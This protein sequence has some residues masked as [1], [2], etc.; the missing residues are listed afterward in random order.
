MQ[1]YTT[2]SREEE[3]QKHTPLYCF[4]LFVL[5]LWEYVMCVFLP[6]VCRRVVRSFSRSA[7]AYFSVQSSTPGNNVDQS[8]PLRATPT[9]CANESKTNRSY[10]RDS[11]VNSRSMD[12]SIAR[13]PLTSLAFKTCIRPYTRVGPLKFQPFIALC[14]LRGPMA[15]VCGCKKA[16]EPFVLHVPRLLHLTTDALGN[17]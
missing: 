1:I 7:S 17:G 13:E 16:A 3:S 2:H 5:V 10:H 8:N 15:C 4:R 9:R 11:R 12:I 14:L 6:P